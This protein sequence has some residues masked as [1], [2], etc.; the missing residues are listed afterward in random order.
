MPNDSTSI[1]YNWHKTEDQNQHAKS[2][3][4]QVGGVYM[5]TYYATRF[6]PGGRNLPDCLHWCL[7]SPMDEFVRVMLSFWIFYKNGDYLL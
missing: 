7:P 5:D 4:K 2:I 1:G 6:R 3:I